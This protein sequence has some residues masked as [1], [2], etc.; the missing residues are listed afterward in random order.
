M[1]IGGF[2]GEV[3]GWKSKTFEGSLNSE[4]FNERSCC[5]RNCHI[6]RSLETRGG[7]NRGK[8]FL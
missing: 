2:D 5:G 1:M 6:K 4:G 3:K 8:L 7:G